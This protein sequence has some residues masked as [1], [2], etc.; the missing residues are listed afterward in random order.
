MHFLQSRHN[1]RTDEYGGDLVNRV[2]LLR[3]LIEATKE[4]VGANCAVALR[5]AVDELRGADGINGEREGREVVEM[6]VELPDLWDVN[7]SGWPNDSKTSRFAAEGYQEQFVRFVKTVT[8][9]PV[10]GVGRFTSP[11][12]MC[13]DS[14][15]R[16][17]HDRGS[18]S[19]DRRSFPAEKDRERGHR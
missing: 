2:R 9:K 19:L 13:R 10:V 3:E 6:L 5:F 4:A 12:T 7:V 1:H 15:R 11:D 16:P 8:T 18:P 17:G 14:T